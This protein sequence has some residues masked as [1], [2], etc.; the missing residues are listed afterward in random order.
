MS[1]PDRPA[2]PGEVR[3][4]LHSWRHPAI[5][6]VAFLSLA[7]GFAQFVVTAAL[8]DVA[9]F[10]GEVADDPMDEVLGVAGQVG[11]SGTTLGIGLAIIRLASLGSMPLAAL[12]DRIGRRIVILT[13]ASAGLLLT[14]VGALAPTFWW[15]IALF[16]LARPLLSATNALAG[17]IAAEET[18]SKHRASAMAL[19]AAGYG[20]GAGLAAIVRGIG[21]EAIGFRTLFALALVPLL[22]V[23]LVSRR[24]EE[25]RRYAHA[26]QVIVDAAAR[27]RFGG[28][29]PHLRGRLV[30]FAGLA[31]AI[32]FATGPMNTYLF[33]F[34][35][36]VLGASPGTMA[37]LV[38]VAG[39]I[40]LV[41]LLLG[42]WGAD[43]LG[44]RLTAGVTQ[45][46]I[47]VAGFV[48]YNLGMPGLFAGYLTAMI[49][50]AAFAPAMSSL[51]AEVFPTHVRSTAA[52]WLA[53]AGVLGAVG[54]LFMFGFLSDHFEAFGPAALAVVIPVGLAA[55]GFAFLPETRGM[56]LEESAPVQ[57]P[58]PGGGPGVGNAR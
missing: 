9:A 13:G 38:G 36:G 22:L 18:T 14:A 8:G 37:V 3:R 56:E 16:A 39:P 25:P 33:V 51:A 41:G 42:R 34:G 19:V 43:N 40:G 4:S 55:V 10:F 23:W 58:D 30:L 20:A 44:R 46:V 35:E 6:S 31:A 21:G 49:A 48:T 15:F 53:A 45:V 54:G 28:V 17:V 11:L 29:D 32:A 12:A 27:P 50:G 52:G 1:G 24:L 57:S 7:S 47:A 5:L 2:T 26:S